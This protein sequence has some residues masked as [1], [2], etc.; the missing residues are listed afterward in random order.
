[1]EAVTC[2]VPAA[3]RSARMS[4]WKLLL[5]FGETTIIQTVVRVALSAC[6]HVIVVTGYRAEELSAVLGGDPRVTLTENKDWELGMFSSIQRGTA[7]VNTER[8]FITLGDKPFIRQGVYTSLLRVDFAEVVFPV[9][10]GERG[11]PVLLRGAVREAVLAADTRTGSMPAVLSRFDA[12]EVDW[13]D[14][15]VILDIDTP[16]EY[17]AI[18][19]PRSV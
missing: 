7:C 5:P 17:N 14:D 18:G 4:R 13:P 8:F 2:V 10:R 15:S 16:Q 12:K 19:G 11:H 3:G 1:M 9:F 6:A